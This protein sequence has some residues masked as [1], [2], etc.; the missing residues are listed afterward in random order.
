[1][2]RAPALSAPIGDAMGSVDY[3][4]GVIRSARYC[5]GGDAV[6]RRPY[7]PVESV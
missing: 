4:A 6:A 2:L 7:P 5:A 1:M 3:V